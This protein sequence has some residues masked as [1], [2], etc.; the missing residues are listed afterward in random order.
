MQPLAAW[1]ALRKL[2][3]NPEQTEEVFKIIRALSG[4]ALERGYHR[5]AKTDVGA[6]ILRE[7]IDL[8]DALTDREA[9]AALPANTLGRHYLHF[10]T[11]ENISADGLVAASQNNEFANLH[12]GLAR[13]GARQ[14]DMHD[15][16][17]TLTQYGR[18]EL[19]EV[20]LLAFTYAQ[21]KN[22][23]VGAICLAGCRQLS[24]YYGS[25]VFRAAR[26]AFRAGK[27]AAWLPAQDWEALL[28]QPIDEVRAMLNIPTPEEYFELMQ[29]PAVAA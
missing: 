27:A 20:C 26:R 28:T 11:S 17:H 6:R 8:L 16:W 24:K 18:N 29:P 2:I 25:G 4:P 3:A 10:V 12:P 5:F 9:L 7:D 15:L 1:R 14:R 21:T 13:F 19:G 22:R 23:G